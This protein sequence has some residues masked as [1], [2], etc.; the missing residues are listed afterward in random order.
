M[1]ATLE[2]GFKSPDHVKKALK[3]IKAKEFS[4]KVSATLS[5]K[6]KILRAKIEGENFAALRARTTSLLRDLKVV[7]D[8]ISLVEATKTKKKK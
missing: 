7:F 4:D 1:K 8:A 3:I 6:G 2:I 5:V